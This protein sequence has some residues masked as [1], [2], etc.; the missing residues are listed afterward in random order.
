MVANVIED[1]FPK[2][3]VI[4]QDDR[5]QALRQQMESRNAEFAKMSEKINSKL[6]GGNLMEKD[7]QVMRKQMEIAEA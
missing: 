3:K 4:T 1:Y 5:T 7:N 6:I 2:P